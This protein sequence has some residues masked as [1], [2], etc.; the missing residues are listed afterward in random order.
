MRIPC[1]IPFMMFLCERSEQKKKNL[2]IFH[3]QSLIFYWN[4]E[5]LWAALTSC[6]HQFFDFTSSARVEPPILRKDCPRQPWSSF[7]IFRPG[8]LPP[9]SGFPPFW[10]PSASRLC[11]HCSLG[12][13]LVG[14]LRVF[15]F[16]SCLSHSICL[17][18]LHRCWELFQTWAWARR[19]LLVSRWSLWQLRNAGCYSSWEV[20][21]F[22]FNSCARLASQ[23]FSVCSF[24]PTPCTA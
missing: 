17:Y 11:L 10:R 14:F 5:K 9:E 6:A 8:L 22:L 7:R 3:P 2:N 16:I 15:F 24:H 4:R 20:S 23:I 12:F 21:W 19:R 13:W 18:L 1:K